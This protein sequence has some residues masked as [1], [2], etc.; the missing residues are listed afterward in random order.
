MLVD[1]AT[2]MFRYFGPS[3]EE[4]TPGAGSLTA[5]QLGR[6]IAVEIFIRVQGQNQ[7]RAQAGETSYIQRIMLPNTQ[8]VIRQGEDE[9]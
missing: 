5:N 6:V 7:G 2:P 1:P 3:G 9:E 4:F 8:A